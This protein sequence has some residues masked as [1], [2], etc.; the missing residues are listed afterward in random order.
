MCARDRLGLVASCR[1]ITASVILSGVGVG[2]GVVE[3]AKEGDV[4]QGWSRVSR[5]VAG[6]WACCKGLSRREG[7]GDKPT[8]AAETGRAG[9]GP[10]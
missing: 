9:E 6:V 5:P 8:T 4:L 1:L 3:W 10:G 7:V 2:V